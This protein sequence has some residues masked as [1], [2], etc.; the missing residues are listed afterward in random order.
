MLCLKKQE[1][2]SG[3]KNSTTDLC[4]KDGVDEQQSWAFASDYFRTQ[5]LKKHGKIEITTELIF[6]SFK[7]LISQSTDS[8]V[9]IKKQNGWFANP[10]VGVYLQFAHNPSASCV[11]VHNCLCFAVVEV[12]GKTAGWSL[13]EITYPLSDACLHLTATQVCAY[14]C[15]CLC[16]PPSTGDKPI[17]DNQA[18]A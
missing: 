18:W 4:W 13:L 14:S 6:L 17:P 7:S 1:L 9:Q 5:S 16:K 3:T 11:I 12:K 15:S 10:F 8:K 2:I